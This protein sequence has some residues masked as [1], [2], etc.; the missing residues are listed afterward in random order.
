MQDR[1]TLEKDEKVITKDTIQTTCQP[2][3]NDTACTVSK[4]KVCTGDDGF[5]FGGI[6]DSYTR[7]KGKDFAKAV[8]YINIMQRASKDKDVSVN[9]IFTGKHRTCKKTIL[10][11]L[12]FNCCS[13][14][15]L[16]VDLKLTQCSSNEKALAIHKEN[17][18]AKYI[19]T[20]CSSK[21]PLTGIC[22]AKKKGVK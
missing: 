9:S 22:L 18:R 19:G 14:D 21:I 13:D 20:Y 17:G 6:K 8:T 5:G 7:P 10:P 1:V 12:L 11:G 2:L 15:G 16:L 3:A 4:A